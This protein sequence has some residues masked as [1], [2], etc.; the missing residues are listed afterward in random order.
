MKSPNRTH[1]DSLRDLLVYN[2]AL[3][4]FA[5]TQV[6]VPHPKKDIHRA[7]LPISLLSFCSTL[8]YFE[9]PPCSGKPFLYMEIVLDFFTD[10]AGHI[11]CIRSFGNCKYLHH[12]MIVMTQTYVITF[13]FGLVFSSIQIITLA[14]QQTIRVSVCRKCKRF[15]SS[16]RRRDRLFHGT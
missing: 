6:H 8:N 2:T 14:G 3:S 13:F 5:G 9:N 15:F 12:Q 1:T 7:F 16:P 4:C 11:Y 10:S